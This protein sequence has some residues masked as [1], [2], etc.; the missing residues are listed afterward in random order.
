MQVIGNDLQMV[1][2]EQRPGNGF[3]GGADVDEQRGMIGDLGGDGFG[4]ALLLV[5][6]LIGAHGVGGVFHA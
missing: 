2:I 1:V 5:A 4:D 6:H 3:G